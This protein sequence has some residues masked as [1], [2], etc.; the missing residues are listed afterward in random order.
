MTGKGERSVSSGPPGERPL[1]F[2]SYSRQ[3]ADWRRRFE[4]ML[5]PVVRRRGIEV[6][7]ERRNE[8]GYEWRP[9]LEQ[10]IARSQLALLLV[11]R[12]FLASEFIMD[13]ELPA[14]IEHGV[15]LVPVLVSNC[16]WEQEPLLEP[17]QWAHDPNRDG[18]VEQ[19]ADQE[20]AIVA[21]CRELV[22]LLPADLSSPVRAVDPTPVQPV[23]ASTRPIDAG[24]KAGELDGVPPLP[25]GV[26]ARAEL[27]GLR[28]ALLAARTGAAGVAGEPLGLHGEGG[29]G[30]S[31]LASALARED[32]VRR[33]FP[34][35]IFWVSVGENPDLLAA[36]ID[37]LQRLG[38]QGSEPRAAADAA[39]RLREALGD[40]RVLLVVDDVWSLAAAQAFRVTGPY[41]R[42]LY[43]TRDPAVL[44]SVGRE[45]PADRRAPRRRCPSAALKSHWHTRAAGGSRPGARR[46]RPGGAR[47]L[48]RRSRDRRRPGLAK[49]LTVLDRGS[50]TF[51]DHPYANVF[52]AMQVGIATLDERDE[53][54][55]RA[56]AAYPEDTLIPTATVARL[57]S[58]PYPASAE[59]TEQRVQTLAA[60][61]LLTL[62]GDGIRFHDLQRVFLLLHTPNLALL[63]AQLL[64]AYRALLPTKNSSLAELPSDEPYIWEHLVYHLRGA[65][66]GTTIIVLLRDLAYLA[67][68][69]FLGGPHAAES[70]LRQAVTLYPNHPAIN[71]L[72]RFFTQWGICSSTTPSPRSATL[73]RPSPAGLPKPRVRST[74]TDSITSSRNPTWRR[75]GVCYPATRGLPAC[76][77]VTPAR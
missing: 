57:W 6:W 70:D 54:A 64:S 34:D 50:E 61:K 31:V 10:A 22:T 9:Q 23:S 3:D 7:S 59:E 65:G 26:V 45:R 15:H 77:Q 76:S 20:G 19:A 49:V 16:L 53:R 72:L 58:H 35:G 40:R 75:G 67:Q 1:V 11:S 68:R 17:L 30:K 32:L 41:G 24:G 38:V 74:A 4:E 14:L 37:L 51:S 29:I 5:A 12:P 13:R 69:C 63:H 39:E 52:K 25:A 66:E 71:W 46:D 44:A 48:A 27:D 2:V 36:Q 28:E 56:L 60:K 18:P 21:L 47:R 43:T 8:I 42:V 62:E 73:R 55:Y 33:Y